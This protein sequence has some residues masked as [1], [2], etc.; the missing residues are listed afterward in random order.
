AAWYNYVSCNGAWGWH[1]KRLDAA[2]SHQRRQHMATIPHGK[3]SHNA[4]AIADLTGYEDAET[5]AWDKAC[6]EAADC[7]TATPTAALATAEK[8]RLG[9]GLDLARSGAVVVYDDGTIDVQGAGDIYTWKVGGHCPCPDH[10][11][12]PTTLCKHMVAVVI[13]QEALR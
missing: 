9:K 5:M 7:L 1:S 11:R 4:H 12:Y 8:T 10:L 3:A 13:H 2:L 6:L